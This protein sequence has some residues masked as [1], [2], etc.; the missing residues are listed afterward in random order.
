MFEQKNYQIIIYYKYVNI[1]EP[2][3]LV[4]QQKELCANLNL[5]GRILI[6]A[7]GINGTVEGTIEEIE[8]YCKD[9]LAKPEFRDMK[10][11]VTP[12]TGNAFPKLSIK[13]RKEIVS[14]HLGEQDFH[15][16]EFSGKYL[17][18]EELHRWFEEG[19]EFYI[20]DM[21]NDYE[22][23]VGH[24]ENSV[25]SGMTNF[26]DLGKII[27]NIE[28]LRDK[29]VVTVCT[30]GVRCEKASG[31]LVKYGFADVYQLQDGIGTYMQKYPN[32]KFLGK[33]YVFDG[34]ITLGFNTEDPAYKVVGKCEHCSRPSENYINCAY[35]E[36]HKHFIC[37]E[38][39][40]VNGESY[41]S[42]NCQIQ[43]E[44]LEVKV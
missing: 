35:P 12:G 11:K 34:R 8:A 39:C 13:L 15:P 30:Y 18:V 42:Q 7:E 1:T 24:F 31:L 21:R 19:R 37:C 40:L 14:S 33:L 29:T 36:C 2:E 20:I 28:H 26:R 25:F 43:K 16:S 5:K 10:I 22:Q 9:L 38:D 44:S 32:H 3:K 17:S 41:C 4:D 27:P 6:A 23:K